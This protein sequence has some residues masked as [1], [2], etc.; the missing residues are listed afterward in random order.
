MAVYSVSISSVPSSVRFVY[1]W[2]RAFHKI[3]SAYALPIPAINFQDQKP[4]I[5]IIDQ[6]INHQKTKPDAEMSALEVKID[7]IVYKLYGLTED[8]I[9]IVEESVRR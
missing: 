3:S 5:H 2:M 1:G 6:I 4:I 9:A 7:R 8:E